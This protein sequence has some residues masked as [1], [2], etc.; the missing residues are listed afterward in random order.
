MSAADEYFKEKEQIDDLLGRGFTIAGIR[1]DLD[2]ADVTFKRIG[3]DVEY[4][5]LRLLTADARKYVSTFIVQ[6]FKQPNA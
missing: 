2:G 1:E 4:E 5:G 3:T 6:Y